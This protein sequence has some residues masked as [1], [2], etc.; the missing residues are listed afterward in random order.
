MVD[1]TVVNILYIGTAMTT[2]TI[3]RNPYVIYSIANRVSRNMRT[4]IGHA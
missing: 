4:L 1:V 2:H 3:V